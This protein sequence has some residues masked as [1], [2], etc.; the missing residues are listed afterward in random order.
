[1]KTIEERAQIAGQVYQFCKER[2]EA[3]HKVYE[4]GYIQGATEQKELDIEK[5]CEWWNKELREVN[6]GTYNEAI[7]A[8]RKA[9]EE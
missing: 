8:F 3:D 5:A 6:Y 4:K 1:M 9:M 2:I 7:N